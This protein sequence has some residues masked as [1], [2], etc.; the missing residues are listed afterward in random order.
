[1]VRNSCA[2]LFI[3]LYFTYM[4]FSYIYFLFKIPSDVNMLSL[5]L[6]KITAEERSHGHRGETVISSTKHCIWLTFELY[7]AI[8]KGQSL[9][10]IF[11]FLT[12]WISTTSLGRSLLKCWKWVDWTVCLQLHRQAAPHLGLI[13]SCVLKSYAVGLQDQYL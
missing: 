2:L 11:I 8:S 13:S 9:L 10:K 7:S 3:L 4:D 5:H 1:M 6:D 12:Y